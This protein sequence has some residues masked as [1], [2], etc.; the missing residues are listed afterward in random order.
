MEA[1]VKCLESVLTSSRSTVAVQVEIGYADD[2]EIYVD[3]Q[4]VSELE[5]GLSEREMNELEGIAYTESKHLDT[6]VAQFAHQ[7]YDYLYG[8]CHHKSLQYNGYT[9]YTKAKQEYERAMERQKAYVPISGK[10]PI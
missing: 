4:P 3:L 2:E 8:L 7:I 9:A 1:I 6:L 10:F 5:G